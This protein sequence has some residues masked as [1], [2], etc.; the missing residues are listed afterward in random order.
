MKYS[1]VFTAVLLVA[2]CLAFLS[3]SSG[4]TE[5][6]IVG[7]WQS[8][9]LPNL[10]MEFN[11]DHTSTGGNWSFTKDGHIK[12]VNPDGKVHLAKLKDG[13]LIFPEF[14]ERGIFVKET[15]KK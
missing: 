6:D 10:W 11:V 13:K 1:K 14:G 3:C 5:K 7:K 12:V 4:P 8:T 15:Q 2:L 9:K